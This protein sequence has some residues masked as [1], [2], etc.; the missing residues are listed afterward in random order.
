MKNL[1]LICTALITFCSANV[2]HAADIT[3]TVFFE[4]LYDIPVM[5]GLAE[6]KAASV[7]FDKAEGRIAH[8]TA[9]NN[10]LAQ[11]DILSFYNKVLPQMG[12]VISENASYVREDETL[13]IIFKTNENQRLVKFLLKPLAQ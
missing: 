1:V 12:W 2:G 6:I 13:S 4:S 5:E 10:N 11:N 7:S 3:Q 9:Q 8:A